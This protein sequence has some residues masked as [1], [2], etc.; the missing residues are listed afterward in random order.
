MLLQQLEELTQTLV[1]SQNSNQVTVK[2]KLLVNYNIELVQTNPSIEA[3]KY[4]EG[5][6]G[7][8][9]SSMTR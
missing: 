3:I 1:T 5:L 4:K 8:S 6:S 9:Q 2:Y 7:H